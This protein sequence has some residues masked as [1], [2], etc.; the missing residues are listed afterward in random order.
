MDDR[1]DL[2]STLTAIVV[3]VV[4]VAVIL[5]LLVRFQVLVVR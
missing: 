1:T 3:V 5:A 2:P 4:G